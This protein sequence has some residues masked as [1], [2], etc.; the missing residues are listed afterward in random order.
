MLKIF[1]ETKAVEST[2]LFFYFRFSKKQ[3]DG[4]KLI[5]AIPDV[6]ILQIFDILWQFLKLHIPISN[7]LC[8]AL[9]TVLSSV[10][11]FKRILMEQFIF[12]PVAFKVSTYT[13]CENLY[14]IWISIFPPVL[15]MR[16][17][18]FGRL[19]FAIGIITHGWQYEN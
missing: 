8:P 11:V 5:S 1:M 15:E 18:L 10:S 6:I 12:S 9:W 4:L 19:V 13:N 17:N 3:Y 7:S 16:L 14:A 2:F